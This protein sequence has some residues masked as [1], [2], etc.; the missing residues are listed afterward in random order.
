MSENHSIVTQFDCNHVKATD[1]T[2]D[3]ALSHMVCQNTLVKI[4]HNYV[5]YIKQ[6]SLLETVVKAEQF[7]AKNV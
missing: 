4:V 6:I 5:P 1:F 3:N 7:I 2:G